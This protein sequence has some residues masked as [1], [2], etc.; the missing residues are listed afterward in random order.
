MATL[1]LYSYTL[2]LWQQLVFMEGMFTQ[3]WSQA[4]AFF[5][6]L[7]FSAFS[8]RFIETPF[9]DLGRRLSPP[10]AAAQPAT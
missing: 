3:W 9:R 7:A 5:G 8:F 2:Y 4:L 6:A 1:G 10:R